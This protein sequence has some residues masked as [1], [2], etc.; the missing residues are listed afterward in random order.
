M[1]LIKKNIFIIFIS[2]FLGNCQTLS[3]V[4]KTMSGEKDYSTDEFLIKKKDP[5]ILPPEFDELPL[6]KSSQKT[7]ENNNKV[8]SILSTE[9]TSSSEGNKSISNLEKKILEEIRRN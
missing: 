5:L 1:K 2:L 3:E 9:E 4:K 7:K 8:K 6:P